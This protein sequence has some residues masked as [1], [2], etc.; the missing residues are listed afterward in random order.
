MNPGPARTM[1]TTAYNDQVPVRP[2]RPVRDRAHGA[3]DA[4]VRSHCGSR[5]FPGGD[6][7]D[8]G[9]RTG[10]TRSQPSWFLDSPRRPRC[11]N[12]RSP[13]PPVRR[14]QPSPHGEL[15]HQPKWDRRVRRCASRR[16]AETREEAAD[17]QA[18]HLRA[19]RGRLLS[20]AVRSRP[21]LD[22]APSCRSRAH[23]RRAVLR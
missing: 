17:G 19:C 6:D 3:R 4:R 9:S 22:S 8:P 12:C 13:R 23:F 15:F 7:P 5:F 18:L 20:D 1:R 11:R 16:P 2:V 14:R 21:A 10:R